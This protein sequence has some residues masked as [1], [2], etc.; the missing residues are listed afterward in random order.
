VDGIVVAAHLALDVARQRELQVVLAGE[1]LAGEQ[2][3][4]GDPVQR[5]RPVDRLE[6]QVP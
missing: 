2:A 3:V 5:R 1:P 6:L 4:P